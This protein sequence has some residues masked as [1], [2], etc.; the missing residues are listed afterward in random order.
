MSSSVCTC[1]DFATFKKN[2]GWM[3]STPIAGPSASTCFSAKV[4]HE[5]RE[6]AAAHLCPELLVQHLGQARS[7]E[8]RLQ[9]NLALELQVEEHR[10]LIGCCGA[11]LQPSPL[12]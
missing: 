6:A 12:P 7:E 9:L 5:L 1:A 11:S 3:Q 10:S 2:R 4:L 8:A